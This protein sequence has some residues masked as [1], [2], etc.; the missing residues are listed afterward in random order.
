MLSNL[1]IFLREMRKEHEEKM[2][3]IIINLR[4]GCS[5]RGNACLCGSFEWGGSGETE[6][7]EAQ[8]YGIESYGTESTETENNTEQPIQDEY[9]YDVQTE[10]DASDEYGVQVEQAKKGGN[11]N[12]NYP[13]NIIPT[14]KTAAS[15]GCLLAGVKGTY[16][17]DAQNALDLINQ[18]R[19]EACDNGYPD[20]RDA[21]RKLTSSDYKPIK[22]SSDL[23][24]I[25]RIRAAEAS[26][27][28]SHTR[29]NGESCF[30]LSS[31]NGIE[32]YGEVL[33]ME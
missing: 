27:L 18:Y 28:I 12:W 23:E 31:P 3:C 2:D 24:Y 14:D 19:K 4:Y 10:Q 30:S 1:M 13:D 6:S 9:G 29:P 15:E 33:G 5:L 21:N 25:A 11:I 32:S 17:A 22:W 8:T 20:P 26:V 16:L 7:Y